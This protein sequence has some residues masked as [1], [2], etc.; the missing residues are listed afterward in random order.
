MRPQL[1]GVLPLVPALAAA[2][3]PPGI[4]G[5]KIV[6]SDDFG[7]SAGSTPSGKWDIAMSIDTNS[8]A[9]TYTQASANVQLSGGGSV[10]F[11][12]RKS[13]SGHWTSGRIEMKDAHTPAPGKQTVIQASIRL[14]DNAAANKQGIW[15][16]F[17]ML[18]DAVRHGT[19]WPQC[20]ELDIMEQ[21]N[22]AMTAY[23]TAH[24][25]TDPG[26]PCQETNG[27]GATIDIPDNGWHTW[28]LKWDRGSSDWKQ[29][30]IEFSRDGQVFNTITGASFGDDEATFGT[31]AHSP[32]YILMNVA[33][34]GDWPGQP[35]AETIGDYG[36]CSPASSDGAVG[37]C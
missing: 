8:E 28:S 35:N 18:G 36:T 25:G 27:L 4:P 11:V 23:G 31:L 13:T 22:G 10:Q 2:I 3:A 15:P 6:W 30:S 29:Q 14:G 17:W 1:G 34:G 5:M 37:D 20:G 16:A 26:G 33:V 19:Q 7:G 32:M 21:V 12:P 9:Q 24:C